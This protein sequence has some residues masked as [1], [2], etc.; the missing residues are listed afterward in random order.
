VP[1]LV[2]AIKEQQKTIEGQQ[3]V[4]KEFSEQLASFKG[5]VNRLKSKDM[6]AQK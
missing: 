3:S 5:E 1:V 6:S 2:E 4:I